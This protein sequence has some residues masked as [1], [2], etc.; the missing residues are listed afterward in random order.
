MGKMNYVYF[1][2]QDL[3]NYVSIIEIK[4]Y[5]SRFTRRLYNVTPWSSF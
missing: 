3:K 2:S 4:H 5:S 1:K